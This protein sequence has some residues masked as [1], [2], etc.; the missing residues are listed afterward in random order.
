MSVRSVNGMRGDVPAPRPQGGGSG[1]DVILGVV[2]LMA[3]GA[4]GYFGFTT[5]LAPGETVAAAKP[6]PQMVA[7]VVDVA[8]TEDDTALC[9]QKAKG[10]ARRAK[11]VAP[12][13]VNPSLAPGFAAMATLLECHIETK[14]ARFCQQDAKATLVAEV[15]DYIG[16]LDLIIAALELQ[17][18]PMQMM[19][20][21]NGEISL[22]S[23]IYEMQKDATLEFML[24][25]HNRVADGLRSLARDGLVTEAD[26][27]AFL[28][29]GVPPMVKRMLKDIAP[30]ANGC[31]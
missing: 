9:E 20:G 15:I 1:I 23:D 19:S 27:G 21:M 8:W 31:A 30:A 6:A 18:V 17:G 16:R 11:G 29:M 10:E 13:S 7:S 3:V 22:G 28:G 5:F 4:L 12:P 24:G 26:F 14:A 25:Y 2:A